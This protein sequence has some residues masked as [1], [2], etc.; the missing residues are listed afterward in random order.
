MPPDLDIATMDLRF[1]SPGSAHIPNNSAEVAEIHLS[2]ATIHQRLD[3][4]GAYKPVQAVI[5]KTGLPIRTSDI[6]QTDDDNNLPDCGASRSCV[7]VRRHDNIERADWIVPDVVAGGATGMVV[8]QTDGAMQVFSADHPDQ[9]LK[10]A[11]FS[12][13]NADAGQFFNL[14][15]FSAQGTTVI[16][17]CDGEQNVTVVSGHAKV[18]LPMLGNGL[19]E[20]PSALEASYKVCENKFREAHISFNIYPP[21][22]PA[23]ASGLVLES[24]SGDVT[25]SE[26]Y[27]QIAMSVGFR[28]YDGA[29]VTRGEG[30]I[31]IDTRG[32]FRLS[33]QAQLVGIFSATGSLAVGWSPLDILFEAGMTFQDWLA[34]SLR[35]H[36]W[37]GQGYGGQYT[38]LP[39]NNDF[40]FTGAI[41]ATFTLKKGRIGEFWKITLPPKDIKLGVEVSF[42]EFCKNE[43]CTSY[44]WGV[45]G[46]ITILSF[47]VGVFVGK[48]QRVNFF[49]GDKG[50]KL[51]DQ[52]FLAQA[53]TLEAAP[54]SP[55][56]DLAGGEP[57]DAFAGAGEGPC[58][59]EGG[60][61]TCSFTVDAGTGEVLISAT[62]ADGT[63]PTAM[64]HTPDGESIMAF[65]PGGLP[66]P[67]VH[68]DFGSGV[69]V[70]LFEPANSGRVQFILDPT[71]AFYTIENPQAGEWQLTLDNLT[72]FENYNVIFAANSPAPQIALTAPDDIQLNGML[73]IQWTATPPGTDATVHLA[74]ISQ[75]DYI[76][77]TTEL[78]AGA[79]ITE[80]AGYHGGVTIAPN[81]P[82]AN[83]SFQWQPVGLASGAYYVVARIDHPIHGSSYAFSPGP[84][85]YTDSTAP[86]PPSGLRLTSA[87]DLADAALI[88]SWDRSS[89]SDL[90]A[91][92]LAYNSP[93]GEGGF[94]ERLLRV[95][96]SDR[97]LNNPERERVRLSA[98]VEGIETT[99]CVRAVDSSGNVSACS[100]SVSAT[101]EAVTSL[102][103]WTAPDLTTLAAQPGPTLAAQW[104]AGSG[105]DGYLLSWAYGCASTYAG[106]PAME[107]P[108]NL[109]VGNVTSFSLTQLP[110]G[111]YRVAVRGYRLSTEK[112]PVVDR[113][114]RY[115]N[116][117]TVLLSDGVDGNGDGLPD[118]W[119]E[120]FWCAGCG[121]GC[122]WRQSQQRL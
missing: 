17:E 49:L 112:A 105:N 97:L 13:L 82:V 81:V 109:D 85:T 3:L 48:G 118:D 35:L 12:A 61:A 113:I 79:P 54:T 73:D 28:A 46:K 1:H 108:S 69:A 100:E 51:I 103:L 36:M 40:H 23:G 106:P 110:P 93:D 63:L 9:G 86:A 7:D 120:P 95:P 75:S 21:G 90:S 121:G 102:P 50:V 30:G 91:Y 2:D 55:I 115:S 80:V 122:G 58:P 88:A 26:S 64:L 34:G 62:W 18:S 98:L 96:P 33:G 76:S 74:Y 72:G 114:G 78:G 41:G 104:M 19:D 53:A 111:T 56:S 92:E 107:G 25:V 65:A 42:G 89:E 59:L 45:Q 37:R 119:A 11:S 27:V 39:D 47:T 4:G 10:A 117:M 60:V 14:K 15:T 70:Y 116:N 38:W 71:N 29:T 66:M 101:P 67:T 94:V 24:L 43:S 68:P 5:R 84:F 32:L 87:F 20:A 16:G 83:G 22:I 44:E 31:L 99:L 57:L 77:F 52:A 8:M 6:S